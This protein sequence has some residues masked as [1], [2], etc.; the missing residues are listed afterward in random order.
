MRLMKSPSDENVLPKLTGGAGRKNT[1]QRK[2][3]KELKNENAS[4]FAPTVT[5]CFP[6]NRLKLFV[7]CHTSRSKMLCIVDVSLLR[8]KRVSTLTLKVLG[9]VPIFRAR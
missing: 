3:L 2:M 8:L 5:T 9:L 4:K 1:P 6:R 7:S